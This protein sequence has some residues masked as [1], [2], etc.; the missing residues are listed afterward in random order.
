[1]ATTSRTQL[2]YWQS[3][4][5]VTGS[6][7][8]STDVLHTYQAGRERGL[9]L[10]FDPADGSTQSVCYFFFFSFYQA[11]PV[12][13]WKVLFLKRYY[14]SSLFLLR[15][16]FCILLDEQLNREVEEGKSF[17]NIGQE[18]GSVGIDLKNKQT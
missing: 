14:Y 12:S 5:D 10:S 17:E 15:F 16:F 18:I 4:C 1:M 7:T 2:G 13:I 3:I 8:N 9:L 6:Q 11:V